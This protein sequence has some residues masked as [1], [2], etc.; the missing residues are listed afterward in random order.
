MT[1]IKDRW[2]E[3]IL[4][5]VGDD[6]ERAKE[7]YTEYRKWMKATFIEIMLILGIMVAI[8]TGTM[9]GMY[10]FGADF[11]G[12]PPDERD[13]VEVMFLLIGAIL[14]ILCVFTRDGMEIK[15]KRRME[16]IEYHE[17]KM[18]EEQCK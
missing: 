10:L 1:K 6:S 3:L 14:G 8:A 12:N 5:S 7:F 15:L 18:E 17:K 11:N 4:E 16:N 13:I 2:A 9:F